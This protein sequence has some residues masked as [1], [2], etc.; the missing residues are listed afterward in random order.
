MA[1]ADDAVCDAVAALLI[2]FQLLIIEGVDDHEAFMPVAAEGGE[3]GPVI[4]QVMDMA[5]VALEVTELLAGGGADF[6][7]FR[8]FGKG[9]GE[10]VF[11][12]FPAVGAWFGGAFGE[13]GVQVI[14]DAFG[15]FAGIVEEFEVGGIGDA[16]GGAGG[17]D[18]EFSV[19]V[20]GGECFIRG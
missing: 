19:R 18:E 3:R 15:F 17:V 16:G 20:R 7:G 14:D 10:E 13:G 9:D 4:Q 8:F 12:G 1:D 11:A 6:V 2:H 5:R